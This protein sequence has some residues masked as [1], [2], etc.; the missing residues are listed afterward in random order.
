MLKKVKEICAASNLEISDS[1]LDRACR[2][3]K[4]YFDK[5]KKAN[6]KSIIVYFNTFPPRTLLCRAKKDRKQ[7]TGYKTRLDLTRRHYLMLSGANKLASDN[8]NANF[9]YADTNCRL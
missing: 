5:L 9:C 4:P 3:G 1:N 6:C 7:K 8:Q 2:I